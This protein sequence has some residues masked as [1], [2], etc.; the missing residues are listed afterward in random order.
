[1]IVQF[2]NVT[3]SQ[4]QAR[5]SP[6]TT[7]LRTSTFLACQNASFVSK[8]QFSNTALSM[9]WKEYLPL[10]STLPKRMFSA[11]IMKYSLSAWVSFIST[12]RLDQ[13]NSGL[14]MSLPAI[15]TFWHSRSALMP[16]ILT[17]S[18]SMLL[19]YHS[20]ARHMSVISLSRMM[21]LCTC[22]QG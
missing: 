4:Y 17:F 20:A 14:T 8:R 22:Q 1:M 3:F 21:R 15:F 18:I 10:K 11:L 9:Y 16:C 7:Q 13:P 5:Y 2:S 12:S 6:L 19:E